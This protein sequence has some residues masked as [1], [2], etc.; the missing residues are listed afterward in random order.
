MRTSDLDWSPAQ[1]QALQKNLGT[2][3]ATPETSLDRHW[4]Q[5]GFYWH[6]GVPGS[7]TAD[8]LNFLHQWATE[9]MGRRTLWLTS[10]I[11]LTITF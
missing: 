10:K 11:L 8:Q 5:L 4:R 3:F 1:E 6:V 7:V 2:H 9:W